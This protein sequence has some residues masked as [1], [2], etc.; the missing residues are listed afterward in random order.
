LTDQSFCPFAPGDRFVPVPLL[1][2]SARYPTGSGRVLQLA[3]DGRPK[4]TVSTGRT[5]LISAMGIGP[6]GVLWVL[7]PQARSVDRFGPDGKLLPPLP[8]PSRGFGSILFEAGGTILLGEHLAGAAGPFAGEGKAVRLAAG[9]A[10]LESFDTEFNG[11]VGGFLGVTHIALST[12]GKTLFHVSETG[13]E[14]YAHDLA[15]NSRLGS[16]YTRTDPPP[17]LFGLAA[18]PDGRL[19][20]AT[21][22]AIRLL[23]PDGAP[24]GD[25]ALPQGRGWA[26]LVVG[27]NGKALLALDF[28]GG[29][30][31]ELA[32]PDLALV[33]VVDFGNPQGMTTVAEVG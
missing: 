3:G 16:I 7:D 8:L 32:L 24:L 4:A 10:L 17:M 9:G 12:D 21:G 14:L 20:V 27:P 26:N 2:A 23:W 30:M 11:G 33:S 22:T 28:F 25:I 1:D 29:R 15:G 6:D 5:G 19:A 31:A 13:P 18:L